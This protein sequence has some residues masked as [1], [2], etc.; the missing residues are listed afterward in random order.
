MIAPQPRADA[1]Q[2]ADAWD[3]Q[4]QAGQPTGT[5]TASAEAPHRG[6]GQETTFAGAAAAAEDAQGVV[7]AGGDLRR[8]QGRRPRRGQLQGQR[9]PV[10]ADADLR[11]RGRRR[12]VQHERRR[13]VAGPLDEQPDRLQLGQAVQGRQVVQVGEGERRRA[14]G[15]L[16]AT[17]SGSRLVASTTT[18]GQLRSRAAAS[19]AQASRRCSRRCPGRPAAAAR[20]AAGP[21]R[22][23]PSR[24]RAAARPAPTRPSGAPARDARATPARRRG[25]RPDSC[26]PAWP[27]PRGPAWSCRRRRGRSG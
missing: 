8:G 12:R 11:H 26:R 22:P 9:H 25:R 18:S 6:C 24:S 1:G 14:P 16:P 15:H 19:R 13:G 20:P 7:E 27:R 5:R 23:R 21:A 17:R 10:Q 4:D 3:G 2:P